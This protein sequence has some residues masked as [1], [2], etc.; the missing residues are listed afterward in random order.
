MSHCPADT[1]RKRDTN[2]FPT[3]STA[4]KNHLT[5]HNAVPTVL[6]GVAR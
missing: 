6:L 5:R 3:V 4:A 2:V 1:Y